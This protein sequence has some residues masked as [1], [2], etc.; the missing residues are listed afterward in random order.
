MKYISGDIFEE[1]RRRRF[2][3]A[4]QDLHDELGHLIILTDFVFWAGHIDELVDWCQ[5][6]G[7]EI[8][9]STVLFQQEQEVTAFVLRWS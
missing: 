3:L 9:G 1:W 2:V 6:N 4:G 7:G 5:S 8:N